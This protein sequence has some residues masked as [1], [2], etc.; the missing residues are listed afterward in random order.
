MGVKKPPKN[1]MS[2][3]GIVGVILGNNPNVKGVGLV[4]FIHSRGF[5]LYV[6][7]RINPVK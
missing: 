7:T 4:I 6:N 1:I 3:G 5:R 2:A